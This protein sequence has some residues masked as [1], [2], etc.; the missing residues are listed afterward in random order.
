MSLIK[1]SNSLTRKIGK[2]TFS[3]RNFNQLLGIDET[4]HIPIIKDSDDFVLGMM[5]QTQINMK[6]K[7]ISFEHEDSVNSVVFSVDG[8]YAASGSDD[9]SIKVWNLIDHKEQ[10]TLK[11][12]P[13]DS[14]KFSSNNSSKNNLGETVKNATIN[15]Q[16]YSS[17]YTSNNLKEA[18][19]SSSS[20]VYSPI[21][22]S[23]V[24]SVAFLQMA[25]IWQEV[26]IME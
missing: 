21:E 10:F 12:I 13:I 22:L 6:R 15:Q 4:L 23:S 2:A 11:E 20:R 24:K 8:I 7:N 16:I 5:E 19:L 25:N 14:I 1:N 18:L 3:D 9:K 26:W 17:S